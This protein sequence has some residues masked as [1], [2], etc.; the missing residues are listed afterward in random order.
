MKMP[1]VR[2]SVRAALVVVAFIAAVLG[3]YLYGWREGQRQPRDPLER[4]ALRFVG[5][6]QTSSDE[7]ASAIYQQALRHERELPGFL[8]EFNLTSIKRLPPDP[9]FPERDMW[10]TIFVSP[11]TGAAYEDHGEVSIYSLSE[12]RAALGR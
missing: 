11:K 12:Y 6:I 5:A 2:F 1:R 10:A 9:R 7:E 4:R 3:A 8:A